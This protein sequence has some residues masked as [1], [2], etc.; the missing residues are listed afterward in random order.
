A[1]LEPLA[2]LSGNNTT[3]GATR[4]ME[5]LLNSYPDQIN[6]VLCHNDDSA[7]GALNAIQA[8]G[9]EG[10]TIIGFNGDSFALELIQDGQLEAT[11]AQQPRLMGYQ[12]VETAVRAV[13]GEDVDLNSPVA[14]ALINRDNVADYM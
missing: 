6:L 10:I 11:I 13:R 12:A 5:D 2:M 4:V 1:G 14:T 3:D 8:A 7:V 9:V